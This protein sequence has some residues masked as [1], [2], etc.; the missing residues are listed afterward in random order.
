M[1]LDQIS[2][3]Q[4]TSHVNPVDD[5]LLDSGMFTFL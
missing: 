2:D 4:D 5:I 1:C 3:P